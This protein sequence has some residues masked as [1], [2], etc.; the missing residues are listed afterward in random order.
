MSAV[1]IRKHVRRVLN[2]VLSEPMTAP[3]L[4][5]WA[6]L[7]VRTRRPLIIGVTG[8][9]GK[10]TTT[11]MIA[12]ALEH[13]DARA[14]V[15]AVWHT[16]DNMNDDVG[17]PLTVL[18]YSHWATASIRSRYSVVVAAPLRA[19]KFVLRLSDYPRILVLEFGTHWHGHLHRLVKIA[20]PTI[21]V[22]TV[23]GPAHLERL[24]TIEGVVHEKSAI[25]SAVPESGL[26][27]LGDGHG[28]V[29]HLERAAH[30]PVRKVHGRGEELS[31]AIA[32]TVCGHLGI[33]DELVSR[34]LRDFRR[35]KGRLNQL[36]FAGLTVIDDSHNA[37]PLS[38]KLALDALV[39]AA[40][41]DHRRVAILGE[42]AELGDRSESYHEEIGAYARDRADVLIGVGTLARHYDPQHWFADSGACAAALG[43]LIDAR[44]CVLVKGSASVGLDRVVERLCALAGER[45][46]KPLDT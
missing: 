32:R 7:V 23:I 5:L 10:T 6:R 16:A 31:R 40:R 37:N 39:D 17:L 29:S 28:H 2:K 1:D 24:K 34:A 27:V 42:M 8:S 20:P 41:A 3:W 19:L 15:G 30:A 45:E 26:V 44:D 12:A 25:V 14:A 43:G 9:A 36:R 46:W 33:G 21:G 11:E 4:S 18:G 13:P 22:V 35:P 38:M